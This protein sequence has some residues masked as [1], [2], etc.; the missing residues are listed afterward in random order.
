VSISPFL[1]QPGQGRALWHMGALLT[2]KATGENTDGKFWLAEQTCGE[3]YA[4]PLHRHTREDELFIVLEGGLRV[5][6]GDE[7][8]TADEG[9]TTFAPRGLP[10][11]FQALSPSTRFLILTTPAGFENWFFETGE[12]AKSLTIP[13]P[14]EGP[15]DVGRLLASVQPYGVEIL[16]P[17]APPPGAAHSQ[18]KTG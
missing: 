7:E 2:F 18:A 9:A 15:P 14:P 10:H 3:G 4:S 13:P 1:A 5:K 6:V 11:S 12:P 8:Y 16:A 17:P